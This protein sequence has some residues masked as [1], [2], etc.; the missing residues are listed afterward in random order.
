LECIAFALW[1]RRCDFAW[2]WPCKRGPDLA[3]FYQEEAQPIELPLFGKNRNLTV[4]G[5]LAKD[6]STAGLVKVAARIHE[7]WL[8]QDKLTAQQQRAAAEETLKRL[9]AAIA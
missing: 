2:N 7:N 8:A 1:A 6:P 9:E 5:K 3:K 4:V